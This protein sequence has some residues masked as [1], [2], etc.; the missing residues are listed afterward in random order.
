MYLNVRI[1]IYVIN[2]VKKVSLEFG[3][4]DGEKQT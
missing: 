4:L 1:S 3:V 2:K